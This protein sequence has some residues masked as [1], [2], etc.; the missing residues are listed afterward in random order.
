MADEFQTLETRKAELQRQIATDPPA[1]VRLHPNL[2]EV[3]R[4]RIENLRY[5]EERPNP[6]A[7][8]NYGGG[9]ERRPGTGAYPSCLA[10]I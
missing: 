1:P 7:P 8:P 3:Y 6:F 5:P 10:V 4:Q 2:S 9:A